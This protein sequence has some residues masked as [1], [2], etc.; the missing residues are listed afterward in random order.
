MAKST[1]KTNTSGRTTQASNSYTKNKQTQKN[2]QKT[3]QTTTSNQSSNTLGGA[4]SVSYKDLSHLSPQTLALQ[5]KVYNQTDYTPSQAVQNA[6]GQK[7]NAENAVSNYGPY[8]SKYQASID[9]TL[10]NILNRPSFNYDFN[11]DALYQAYADQYA[12]NGRD[13]A[14]NAAAAASAL[15]GG[16]GNS[17]AVSA[18]NQANEQYMSELNDRIPELYQLAL[19]RYNTEGNNLLNQYNVLGSQEDRNYGQYSTERQNLVSDR[20]YYGSNYN[21][22]RV[23]DQQT[24]QNAYDNAMALLNYNTNLEARDV[25]NSDNWSKTKSNEKTTTKGKETT[26]NKNTQTSKS[27][28]SSV[29]NTSSSS[30]TTG[31]SSGTKSSSK[32]SKSKGDKT[33]SSDYNQIK[34][35]FKKMVDD[36]RDKNGNTN[37]TKYHD[38]WYY[39]QDQVDAGYINE[40]DMQK[41]ATTLNE[42]NK[43]PTK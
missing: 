31:T 23:N 38:A 15:T 43:R 11:A 1:S 17:Y 42:W 34:N 7:T 21:N 19:E 40:S 13:A 25:S 8:N 41:M 30:T 12:K 2:T 4:N 28:D 5:N 16:Y 33:S 18:A 35:Q 37:Q 14:Q 27:K 24:W 26:T 9:E 6:Y 32:S 22:E 36:S 10:Q 29:Q 39:L 20:D 3:N